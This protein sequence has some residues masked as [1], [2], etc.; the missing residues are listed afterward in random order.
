M[1]PVSVLVALAISPAFATVECKGVFEFE[2]GALKA[3]FRCHYRNDRLRQVR[4]T[5]RDGE[6]GCDADGSCD[7]ACRFSLCR[8]AGCAD[9][10]EVTVPLRRGGKPKREVLRS[11][12]TRLVLR[13]L[14]SRGPCG[15]SVTT[16]TVAAPTT[17][18]LPVR[19]CSVT[20]SGAVDAVVACSASISTG[21]LGLPVFDLDIAGAAA[22]ASVAALL[23]GPGTGSYRL[24]QRMILIVARLGRPAD[25]YF[26][27]VPAAAGASGEL[28]I[29]EVASGGAV[30]GEL[31]ATLPGTSGGEPLRIHAEF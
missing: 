23:V 18:T 22:E 1:L 27:A 25:A 10:L 19:P 24:G 15:P 9:T 7:G 14:P 8:D 4:A 30:H 20:L 31:D 29:D 3:R 2:D 28:R 21:G 5:C 11:G 17:T 13:C 26:Q 6:P 12:G 16:T